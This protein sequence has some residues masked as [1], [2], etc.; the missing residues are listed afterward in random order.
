MI[1]LQCRCHLQAR[2]CLRSSPPRVDPIGRRR[3]SIRCPRA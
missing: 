3:I 2:A 1:D